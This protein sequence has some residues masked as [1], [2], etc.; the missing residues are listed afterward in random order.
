[1]NEDNANYTNVGFKCKKVNFI[2]PLLN[3][4]RTDPQFSFAM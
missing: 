3:K 4:M 1:M 2:A